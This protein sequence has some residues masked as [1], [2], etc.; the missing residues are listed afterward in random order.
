MLSVVVAEGEVRAIRDRIIRQ[1]EVDPRVLSRNLN[2]FVAQMDEV[3]AEVRDSAGG[4]K[5]SE[6]EISV[7]IS[8]EGQILLWGVGGQVGAKGGLSL[9]F[10]RPEHSSNSSIAPT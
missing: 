3:L 9:T 2:A 5:L 10:K 4:F 1:I 8:A 6:V 7:E